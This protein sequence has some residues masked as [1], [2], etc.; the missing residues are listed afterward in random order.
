MRLVGQT[1]LGGVVSRATRTWNEHELWLV[2]PS[3]AVQVTTVRP[4][5]NTLPDGGWQTTSGAAPLLSFAAG[6]G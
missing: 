5:G 2:Q 1:M 4:G 3:V 6:A